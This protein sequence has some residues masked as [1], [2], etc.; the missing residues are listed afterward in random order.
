VPY[1]GGTTTLQALWMGVPVVVLAGQHFVSRMGASF[2]TALNL[3]DWVAE[4]DDAYVE[5]ARRQ[6]SDRAALL[7]LKRGLRARQQGS[8]AWDIDRHTRA[9]ERALRVMWKEVCVL[10]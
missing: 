5:I 10:T 7:A 6:A 3:S 1:N 4:S 2:M 8:P 9:V